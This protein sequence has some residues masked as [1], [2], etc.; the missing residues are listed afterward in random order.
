MIASTVAA[1]IIRAT[2]A[3]NLFM[4]G[5]IRFQAKTGKY[6]FVVAYST[7]VLYKNFP[8]EALMT[9]LLPWG[10]VQRVHRSLP[11]PHFSLRRIIQAA[12]RARA[13]IGPQSNSMVR[14]SSFSIRL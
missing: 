11:E 3:S 9:R 13:I 5:S 8:P 2:T 12:R 14:S 1:R 6:T 7:K 10:T 4:R